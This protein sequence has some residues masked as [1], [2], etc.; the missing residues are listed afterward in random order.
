MFENFLNIDANT[1][2]IQLSIISKFKLKFTT[3]KNYID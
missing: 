1:V 2:E 3:V